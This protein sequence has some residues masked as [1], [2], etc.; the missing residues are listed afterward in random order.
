MRELKGSMN[1]RSA[2][3]FFSFRVWL[4]VAIVMICTAGTALAN[5]FQIG[6]FGGIAGSGATHH[7]PF[8]IYW[9][10]A[11]LVDVGFTLQLHGM[12]VNRQASYDRDAELN[13]VPPELEGINSGVGKA[14]A[15]GVVPGFA[16]QSGHDLGGWTIGLGFAAFVDRAGRTNWTKNFAAPPQYPGAVDGPQRWSVIN[17]ELS[18]L[19]LGIGL[20]V[21]HVESALSFGATVFGTQTSLSLLRARTVSSTD[22]V[23]LEGHLTE[24]RVLFRNGEDE[25]FTLVLGMQWEPTDLIKFGLAWQSAVTYQIKGDAL[26]LFGEAEESREPAQTALEVPQGIRGELSFTLSPLITLRPALSWNQWSIAKS[27]VATGTR[28]GEI[29]FRTPREFTDTYE[30][31]LNT[32]FQVTDQHALHV[33]LGVEN[34]ATPKDTYE[35]G[36]AESANA[37]IGGGWTS[38]WSETLSTHVALVWQAFANVTVT[39]SRQAPSTNGRY[40]DHRQFLTIDMEVSL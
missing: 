40:T 39:D 9:N 2:K 21:E 4:V 27:Q 34:G 13:G 26:I 37:R 5:P 17:T 18:L 24:G 11:G 25:G 30:F 35:P 7:S 3:T 14:G 38:D 33:L 31:K 6:R 36:L 1:Q 28:T 32:D 23:T 15:L 19:S 22:E 20:A 29:L 8:A 12:M 10:P 16:L